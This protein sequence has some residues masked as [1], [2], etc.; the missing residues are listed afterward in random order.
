VSEIN[1]QRQNKKGALGKG[2]NSL[3]GFDGT[4]SSN[5]ADQDATASLSGLMSDQ[6]VMR[7]DP[8]DIEPN[9]LQPRKVFRAEELE[10]LAASLKIDGVIQPLIVAKG[11]EPGKYILI[12]GE[13]RWR[14][15]QKIGMD[16]IPVI[17]KDVVDADRLRV[18]LIENIQRSDLTAIEEAQ[19]YASLIEDFGLTQ[20]QCALKVGKDRVSITNTLRLL[21]LPKEIQYDLLNHVLTAG[22]AKALLS[23]ENEDLI[24]KAREV[25]IKKK[26]NV[27]QTE[28]LCRKIKKGGMDPQKAA[29][30]LENADLNYLADHLRNHLRTKVKLAGNGSRGRIEIA[31]FSSSELE[32]IL[33][34]MGL[35]PTL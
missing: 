19:A 22:H 27:R 30:K 34:I 17:L 25:I 26:L 33:N 21:N 12:A 1:D 16:K 5:T 6:M 3:L 14:A 13:R 23:L 31:Y 2:L 11:S 29:R 7:V 9:P 28:L 4:V 35:G 15:A 8:K 20:E 10:S 18:A 24:R 32:R